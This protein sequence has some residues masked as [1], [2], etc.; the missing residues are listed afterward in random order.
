MHRVIRTC[1]LCAAMPLAE[2]WG[3]GREGVFSISCVQALVLF[4]SRCSFLRAYAG[5]F[6]RH[7][8]KL[9]L[10]TCCILLKFRKGGIHQ[11]RNSRAGFTSAL[12]NPC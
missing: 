8:F 5:V 11:I 9:R 3:R 7:E 12:R 1:W 10:G 2:C 6:D 4:W